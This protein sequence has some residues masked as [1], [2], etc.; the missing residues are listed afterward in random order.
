MSATPRTSTLN[1]SHPNLKLLSLQALNNS[2]SKC[3][4]DILNELTL[5]ELYSKEQPIV[6]LRHYKWKR[7]AVLV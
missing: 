3:E 1:L 6:L 4:V 2:L 7:K 5:F